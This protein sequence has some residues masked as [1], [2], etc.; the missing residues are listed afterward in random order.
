MGYFTYTFFTGGEDDPNSK[1]YRGYTTDL[2]KSKQDHLREFP[3]M[4]DWEWW[5]HATEDEMIE[6]NRLRHEQSWYVA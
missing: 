6:I 3:N 5:E 1:H 4:T 2:E